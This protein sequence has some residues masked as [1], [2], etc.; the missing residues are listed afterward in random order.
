[1]CAKRGIN[2]VFEFQRV[3]EAFEFE[4]NG[5]LAMTMSPTNR[6]ITFSQILGCAMLPLIK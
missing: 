2:A 4:P 3:S 6:P 5:S 1:M